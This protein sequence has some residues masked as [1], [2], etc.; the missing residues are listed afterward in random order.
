MRTGKLMSFMDPRW[1]HVSRFCSNR[2]GSVGEIGFECAL[3]EF[4]F[5]FLEFLEVFLVDEDV[6]HFV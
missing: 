4:L 3:F 5:Y 2:T 6:V 1:L